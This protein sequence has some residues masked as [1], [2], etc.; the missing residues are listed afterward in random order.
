MEKR[1]SMYHRIAFHTHFILVA[2]LIILFI[3]I[4][5]PMLVCGKPAIEVN[6]ACVHIFHIFCMNVL[7]R[8]T[9]AD[10]SVNKWATSALIYSTKF[11]LM[12]S[13]I[14]F[15]TFNY[16]M[17]LIYEINYDSIRLYSCHRLILNN[18]TMNVWFEI[19]HSEFL[20]IHCCI[21]MASG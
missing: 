15:L 19:W 17:N 14:I 10:G 4:D 6:Q 3:L 2:R 8:S 1:W 13:M 7:V 21:Q 11:I 18:R 12:L 9:V 20:I 5:F 16:R